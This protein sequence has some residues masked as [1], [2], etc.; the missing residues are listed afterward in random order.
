MNGIFIRVSRCIQYSKILFC[1][2]FSY[3]TLMLP[4][5]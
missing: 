1:R 2:Y 4:A 3:V 5:G